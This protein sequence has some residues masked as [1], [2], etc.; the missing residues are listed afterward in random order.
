MIE[1]KQVKRFSPI[2]GQPVCPD[3]VIAQTRCDYTG[4]VLSRQELF[5]QI[6]LLYEDMDPCWGSTGEEFD[7]EVETGIEISC[8]LRP[9]Y[10]F[11]RAGHKKLAKMA[12][13][14]KL[15]IPTAMRL[16]RVRAA[17]K[18]IRSGAVT[19]DALNGAVCPD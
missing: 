3:W 6:P 8:F 2:N 9:E 16:A 19:A 4:K 7:F 17:L 12:V 10:A 1:Y 14:L 5:P 15:D 11:S 18:L 13:A